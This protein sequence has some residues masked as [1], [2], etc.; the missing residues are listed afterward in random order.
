MAIHPLHRPGAAA[1][2][3][4]I[5]MSAVGLAIMGSLMLIS[6]QQLKRMGDY[7]ASAQT[8]YAAEAG[9]NVGLYHV[10]SSIITPTFYMDFQGHTAATQFSGDNVVIV[11]T[12]GAT[13]YKRVITATATS[14]SGSKRTLRIEATTSSFGAG[15]THAVQS[16]E[17]GFE[18]GNSDIFGDVSGNGSFNGVGANSKIHGNLQIANTAATKNPDASLFSTNNLP[19]DKEFG[20]NAARIDAAQSFSVADDAILQ[21]AQVRLKRKTTASLSDPIT[22]RL[23]RNSTVI[24]VDGS[25]SK[26]PY[27]ILAIATISKSFGSN[28][29]NPNDGWVDI[30]F[31]TTTP[32]STDKVG[33]QLY[34]ND[35]Y[36]MVLDIP[37]INASKYP[38]W[39]FDSTNTSIVNG[40]GKFS[41]DYS[42]G[43][44]SDAGGDFAVKTWIN[45]G[46]TSANNLSLQPYKVCD[47]LLTKVCTNN[48]DCPI[49]GNCVQKSV[50]SISAHVIDSCLVIPPATKTLVDLPPFTFPIKKTEIDQLAATINAG[51]H[52]AAHNVNGSEPPMSSTTIDGDLVLDNNGDK[53]TLS[54]N[55]YVKGNLD[56]G[57]PGVTIQSGDVGSN[58]IYIVV[59]G[60][61]AVDQNA[62][63]LSNGTP[64][65]YII[66]ISK[67][68]SRGL[69]P[70]GTPAI[71]ANNN[72]TAAVYYA[73]NGTIDMQENADLNN[74]S[75]FFV[76]MD[77][78]SKVTY[79]PGLVLVN[80]VP[81]SS[82]PPTIDL[83]SWQEL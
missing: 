60:N 11:T 48:A 26:E 74:A 25:P 34:K 12:I 49:G 20:N 62:H 21:R 55:I 3:M 1:L 58:T 32:P 79:D 69:P 15:F 59:E 68:Y 71:L 72:S 38:I 17:G 56:M 7:K 24:N 43:N 27:D 44:W 51:P 63:I 33:V 82:T 83:N 42:N 47:N 13:P 80:G 23:V 35:I 46:N 75:G 2:I 81:G 10:M 22:V 29:Y 39:N 16:G 9:V 40:L 78:N 50:G 53:L 31:T 30:D 37:T 76:K 28:A 5:S 45:V 70:H 77:N 41:A 54:G 67:S 19:V 65:N 14:Q 36:W 4:V 8:F 18:M 61:I 64:G 73:L 52:I 66:L 6:T 57:H